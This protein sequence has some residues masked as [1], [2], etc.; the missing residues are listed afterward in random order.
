MDQELQELQRFR[1]ETREILSYHQSILM[2]MKESAVLI[3]LSELSKQAAIQATWYPRKGK[4]LTPAERNYR[5]AT[6][7]DRI[8]KASARNDFKDL[9]PHLRILLENPI[10][11]AIVTS[12]PVRQSPE[13]YYERSTNNL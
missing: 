5:I 2:P 10:T 4:K 8:R 1:Q 12:D 6:G 9:P 3:A 13:I 7:R 11:S